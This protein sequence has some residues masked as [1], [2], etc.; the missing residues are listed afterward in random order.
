MLENR[1]MQYQ[2]LGN[3][4]VYVS[5]LCLGAMT[6]G[7][8]GTMFEAIGGLAQKDADALGLNLPQP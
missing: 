1:G 4:G 2:P 8:I 6:F 7:G 5:R 3:T